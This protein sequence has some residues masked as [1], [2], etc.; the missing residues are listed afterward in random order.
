MHSLVLAL[1]VSAAVQL[2]GIHTSD[3][4]PHFYDNHGRVRIFHGINGVNKGFPWYPT[5]LLNETLVQEIAGWGMNAIR[6]GWMFS[7]FEPAEGE[8]NES[9]FD[10]SKEVTQ[11]LAKYGIHTLLDT[12]QD[13]MSSKFC[14]YDGL[15]LWLVNRSHSLLPYPWPYKGNCSS[16]GWGTNC[17]TGAA[18]KAY[19]DFY[20]NKHGMRDEFVKFW[21]E[22]AKRW[23]GDT[24]VLG[25]EL[26]N[27]PFAG[28]VYADPLLFLPGVAGKKNLQPLYDAVQEAI[29]RHD[30][31]HVIFY[32]PVTW[33]MIFKGK[34]VGSGFT[35]VPGGE[36]Y[37]NRSAFS[38]HYYCQSFGDKRKLCDPIIGP[39][40]M[41]AV[42]GEVAEMGGSSMMTEWGGCDGDR[43]DECTTVCDTADANLVSWL[44]YDGFGQGGAFP[45]DGY[46]ATLSRTYAQA[47][48]GEPSK[49]TYNNATSHFEL[50]FDL[51]TSI[52]APTE[53]F[54]PARHYPTGVAITA[55]ANLDVDAAPD[56]KGILRARPAAGASGV[57]PACIQLSQK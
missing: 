53:I 23:A 17:L 31:E 13:C 28:D 11:M 8:F 54:V 51:D 47:I 33:G 48:A 37:K 55:T 34:V 46:I 14:T 32:E 50:C 40:V 45:R 38:F 39:Q 1:G 24:N 16:R 12:H 30:T 36:E 41:H 49:M 21:E 15:P 52:Q 56:A 26:I 44:E 7:G 5:W 2:D 10:K 6:M 3:K 27:E 43:L 25:L 57:S 20:D 19:Q 22:S 35:H 42:L 29:R 18:D 9:Y 4:T